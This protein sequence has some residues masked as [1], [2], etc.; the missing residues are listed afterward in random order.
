MSHDIRRA[1]EVNEYNDLGLIVVGGLIEETNHGYKNEC[2]E[3]TDHERFFWSKFDNLTP[4]LIVRQIPDEIEVDTLTSNDVEKYA[5]KQSPPNPYPHIWLENS[6][7]IALFSCR[8]GE[9]ICAY[10]EMIQFRL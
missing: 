9:W 5:K 3:V 8:D 1:W 4:R 7:E 2:R 6:Y 10:H